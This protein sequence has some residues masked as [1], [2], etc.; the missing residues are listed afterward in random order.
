MST[1]DDNTTELVSSRN[2]FDLHSFANLF[3]V[4]FSPLVTRSSRA[5]EPALARVVVKTRRG[6]SPTGGSRRRRGRENALGLPPPQCVCNFWFVKRDAKRDAV[7]GRIIS[8]KMASNEDDD[9]DD[10]DNAR[11]RRVD[12]RVA[13]CREELLQ[14]DYKVS[15][16][17]A[18][19]ASSAALF[20]SVSAARTTSRAR[21]RAARISSNEFA[22]ALPPSA[23]PLLA[24]VVA[25]GSSGSMYPD[26]KARSAA[27]AARRVV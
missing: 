16:P 4:G 13:M 18:R 12:A 5:S 17:A 24:R 3:T 15:K 21:S 8:R 7:A 20:S 26:G 22:D 11:R 27:S 19:S 1:L 10:D 6:A 25:M 2:R 9:D 14:L 23:A